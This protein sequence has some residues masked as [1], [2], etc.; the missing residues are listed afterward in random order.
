MASNKK[1]YRSTDNRM[2][3]GVCGGFAE[4]L[5]VDPTVV[6]IIYVLLSVLTAGFPG[7]VVYIIASFLMPVDPGYTDV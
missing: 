7:I 1:L 6:R 4:Y 2:I 3:A 5:N